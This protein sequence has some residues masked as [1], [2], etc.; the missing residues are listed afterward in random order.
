MNSTNCFMNLPVV[1]FIHT[2]VT[3]IILQKTA[4]NT[5]AV[6]TGMPL[7]NHQTSINV[8]VCTLE[9]NP[10]NIKTV[11]NIQICVQTLTKIREST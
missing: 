6:T 7:L 10:E 1:Y 8:K 9:K 5:D 4:T 2:L 11:T 3:Q